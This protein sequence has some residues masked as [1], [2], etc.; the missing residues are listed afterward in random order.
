MI[1]YDL[2]DSIQANVE[3]LVHLQGAL[4]AEQ[5][6]GGLTPE[7]EARLEE[8]GAA[9]DGGDEID[10]RLVQARR[11]LRKTGARVVRV[12]V[13]QEE[14]AREVWVDVMYMGKQ[15]KAAPEVTALFEGGLGAALKPALEAQSAGIFKMLATLESQAIYEG[16]LRDKHAPKL[17][18][19][20]DAATQVLER[21]VRD[22]AA[23]AA[24]YAE[25]LVW[26]EQAN[27]LRA[28]VGADLIKLGADRGV[29]S[30][31]EFARSFFGRR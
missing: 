5:E 27:T 22:N 7:L 26:K 24:L 16:A 10:A 6:A 19:S 8:V 29:P 23:L 12:E 9:I 28:V 17:R 25:A 11:E 13:A 20:V 21:R 15:N 1:V 30:P 31:K 4:E 18:A 3:D 2:E 14:A